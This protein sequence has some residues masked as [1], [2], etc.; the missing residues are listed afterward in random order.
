M[1]S[2]NDEEIKAHRDAGK[3][4]RDAGKTLRDAG[5]TPRDA[6]KTPRDEGK[7]PPG[8]SIAPAPGE[9]VLY[10]MSMYKR[11]INRPMNHNVHIQMF[12]Q[13]VSYA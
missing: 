5:K 7:R 3:T 9:N 6:G 4:P 13:H 10:Q 1:T 11:F 8:P 12:T 2:L